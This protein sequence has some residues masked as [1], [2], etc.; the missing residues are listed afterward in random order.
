MGSGFTKIS[1][2]DHVKG[3]YKAYRC[4][5]FEVIRGL[6]S[7]IGWD[8]GDE[9][10]A[11]Y[12]VG[13][14]KVD[15]FMEIKLYREL[16][17]ETGITKIRVKVGHEIYRLRHGFGITLISAAKAGYLNKSLFPYGIR[18]HEWMVSILVSA[19]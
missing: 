19:T 12:H 7:S 17:T 15:E 16:G 5:C 6:R 9:L 10:L 13:K 11:R 3:A 8:N 1:D 14:I 4:V 18:C 2:R